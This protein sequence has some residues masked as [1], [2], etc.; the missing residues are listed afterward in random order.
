MSNGPNEVLGLVVSRGDRIIK[1]LVPEN[2]TI[3]VGQA[4]DCDVVLQHDPSAP[5][6]H[7]LAV[8]RGDEYEFSIDEEMSGKIHVG[9]STISL[10]DLRVCG[11]LP[12]SKHG[13]VFRANRH[14]KGQIKVSDITIHFGYFKPSPKQVAGEPK[15][16]DAVTSGLYLEQDQKVFLGFLGFSFILGGLFILGTELA[17]PPTIEELLAEQYDV[18]DVEI[19]VPTDVVAEGGDSGEEE[20]AEVVAN[21]TSEGA[22]TGGSGGGGGAD[23]ASQG[24]AMGSGAAD[25]MLQAITSNIVAAGGGMTGITSGQGSGLFESGGTVS[26]A[27]GGAG[28]GGTGGDAAAGFGSGGTGTAGIEGTGGMGSSDLPQTVY[29]APVVVSP[30]ID[31][32]GSTASSEGVSKVASF[33]ASRAGTIKR[34]YQSYL[35]DNPGLS[36]RI[37]LNV[38][39]NNGAISASV[40]SNSTGSGALAN[41]IVGTVNSWSVFG[42]DGVVKLKVPFNLEPQS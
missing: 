36:G 2:D 16:A 37:V 4:P 23:A 15:L 28:A 17:E 42:V 26:V 3:T 29:A 12:R 30:Q 20:V 32:G 8:K 7:Q 1:R 13:Y 34:I 25:F 33:F 24:A 21:T 19:E 14:K 22:G 31:Q 6:K 9:D 41:E 5:M 11:F 38:T 39:V 18:E 35:G 40:A 27:G 10:R